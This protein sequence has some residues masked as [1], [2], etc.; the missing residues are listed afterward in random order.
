[1]PLC[2][3]ELFGGLLV[4][5]EHVLTSHPQYVVHRVPGQ[6]WDD[7]SDVGERKGL[8]K[9]TESIELRVVKLDRR[10][11]YA[12]IRAALKSQQMKNALKTTIKAV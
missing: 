4:L 2:G 11:S 10:G 12:G 1:M 8:P 3:T 9:F 5:G 7:C 6:R